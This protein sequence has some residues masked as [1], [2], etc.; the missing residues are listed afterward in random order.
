[1]SR[2]IA[3]QAKDTN[4][5]SLGYWERADAAYRNGEYETAMGIVA[6]AELE[7]KASVELLLLKGACIQLA[8]GTDFPIARALE[9]Y[10]QL[11]ARRPGDPRILSEIGFFHLKVD[12]KPAPAREFFDQAIGI[13]E[14]LI[15]EN[16][17]GQIEA[18][19]SCGATRESAVAGA[20][21]RLLAI[22]D[23]IDRQLAN[24]RS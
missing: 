9:V 15:V 2:Q 1:L 22:A 5:D 7:G 20:K 24:E 11:L 14:K 6:D 4:V 17:C 19:R 16:L 21:Q 23:L 3:L 8:T 10:V 18:H 12:D 13:Y